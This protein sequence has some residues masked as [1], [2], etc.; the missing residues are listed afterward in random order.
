MLEVDFARGRVI[1]NEEL[2]ARYAKE[3][4]YRDWIAEETLTVDALDRP[5][6]ATPA[7][8]AEVPAAVRMAKLG[9]HWDDVDEVV[10]PMAQQGKAP[11][12]SMASTRR[13]PACPRRRVRSLTTSISC[14]LR[15]RTR[16]SMPFASIWSPRPRSTPGQP[17][18]PARGLPY[19]L[20]AGAPGAPA[21]EREEEFD[22]HLRH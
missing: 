12:A 17:R 13:W 7:E 9:Y 10:R 8:D 18:K 19:D 20:P 5:A 16:P 22:P 4:P 11:L 6:A 15:S 21:A 1:Y 14:S 3:K 2:R